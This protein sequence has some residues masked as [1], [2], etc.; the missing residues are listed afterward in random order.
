[1]LKFM[2]HNSVINETSRLVIHLQTD[3]VIAPNLSA[4]QSASIRLSHY[5]FQINGTPHY[6]STKGPFG[7]S[8]EATVRFRVR[9]LNVVVG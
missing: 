4:N 7:H 2:L 8:P 5:T 1:M 9:N 3:L 6:A